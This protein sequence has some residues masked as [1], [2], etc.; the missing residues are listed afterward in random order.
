MSKTIGVITLGNS[1]N[2][3]GVLQ[4]VALNYILKKMGVEPVFITHQKMG[5]AW[6]NPC[7]YVKLRVRLYG[8]KGL[9]TKL[10]ILGGIGKTLLSNLHMAERQKKINN[11]RV[12]IQEN[13]QIT[14]YY[15]TED[16]LKKHCGD[17][18]YYLTGSDQV[19]ND[20]FNFHK[21]NLN[22]LLHFAKPDKRKFSYAAS[23]GGYKDDEYIMN[24]V[25]MTKEF[26]GISVRETSLAEAMNR[27]GADCVQTVLDPTLLLTKEEWISMEKPC[28]VPE[29]YILVYNLESSVLMD[30][31][32]NET[33][34]KYS[35][36]VVDMF[37]CY[38]KLDCV[39]H[40]NATAGPAEFI[41]CFRHADY[42]ITNSFHGT[43]FSILFQKQFLTV[44][45]NGQESRMVDLLNEVGLSEYL[46]MK[47]D[48]NALGKSISYREVAHK[49]ELKKQDSLRFL[50]QMLE[51]ES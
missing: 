27:L 10:R 35:L 47:T 11:F 2:Y 22:Y 38:T 16:E 9:K 14:P 46:V 48:I 32:V 43:V 50:R 25:D 36:P 29:R 13:M 21:L 8:G 18:D 41:Y 7:R 33:V 34:K 28:D 5:S 31:L 30:S 3:G 20:E 42:I 45:R 19:W 49:M 26:T 1:T 37:S 39:T 24:L 23:T 51:M 17:F 40:K 44:P 4:A 15:A 6:N 12:F